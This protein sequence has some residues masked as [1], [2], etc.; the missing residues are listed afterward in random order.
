MDPALFNWLMAFLRG[1]SMLVVFPVFSAAQVPV[2]VRI[3]SAAFLAWFVC[4]PLGGPTPGSH[5]LLGLV[6]TMAVEVCVG[7]ALGFSARLFFY[8]LDMVGAIVTAE[9]GLSLQSTINPMSATPGSTVGTLLNYVAAVIWLSLDLH[10]WLLLGFRRAYELLPIGAAGLGTWTADEMIHRTS[11][12]FLMALQMTGPIIAVSFIIS[13]VFSISWHSRHLR[14]DP[15]HRRPA[16]GQL[17]QPAARRLSPACRHDGALRVL[18]VATGM[19]PEFPPKEPVEE[20]Q[21]VEPVPQSD[22]ADRFHRVAQRPAN[23][24]QADLV[25]E[26]R[27]RFP[28]MSLELSRE[29]RPAHPGQRV[30]IL[31][32][33]RVAV[34]REDVAHRPADRVLMLHRPGQSEGLLGERMQFPLRRIGQH[35]EQ[36]DERGE[37]FQTAQFRELLDLFAG[38]PRCFA[39]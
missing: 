28:R 3:A 23:R 29:G 32:P 31:Q 13:L 35:P 10:H 38:L 30:Q 17:P 16:H 34:V 25:Q 20:R 4:D 37:L 12:T 36:P 24:L 9:M 2:R 11:G 22:G 18:P 7:L 8:A 15:P 19:D 39:P 21:L 1:G 27:E 33:H 6:G 5:D 26:G 14:A